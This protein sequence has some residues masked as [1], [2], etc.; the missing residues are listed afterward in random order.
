LYDGGKIFH[1][2]LF[3]ISNNFFMRKILLLILL[4]FI[5][6]CRSTIYVDVKRPAAIN[7]GSHI[8]SVALIDR[9]D[10]EQNAWNMIEGVLTGEGLLQDRENTQAVLKGMYER[11]TQ[12]NRFDV[13]L[14]NT[15]LKRSG[16]AGS[17]PAPLSWS[18]VERLCRQNNVD[19]IVVLE[20]FDTNWIITNGSVKVDKKDKEGNV[21]PGIEYFAEGVGT[22]KSGMRLYDPSRKS[23][24]DQDNITHV[25]RWRKQGS[26]VQEALAQL[27]E[28]RIAIS[29]V[30]YQTGVQYTNRITPAWTREA[31]TFYNKG[32]KDPWLARGSRKARTGFW[33]DA[34]RDWE[35]VINNSR[36]IK[37]K[38]RA[39]HNI[40]LGHEVLGELP[41]A[42]VWAK[43]AFADYN[44][45]KALSYSRELNIRM[46][47]QQ[48][49][50]EQ[51]NG[52]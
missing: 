23:I 16:T 19:A 42:Q 43:R 17:F 38:G 30:S 40:A 25:M 31:R 36:N 44:N 1:R 52:N 8:K 48:R 28:R 32:A 2:F 39:A 6:S 14:T 10:V 15:K 18:E 13:R 29:N 21:I 49:L 12:S 22:V 47:N 20:S 41:M 7:V 45:R 26:S 27:I 9:T 35:Y 50:N 11:M 51:F 4:P 37:A 5:F 3:Y 34:I 46:R 24:A 33:E